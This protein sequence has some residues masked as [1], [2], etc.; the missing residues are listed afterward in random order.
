MTAHSM[1]VACGMAVLAIGALDPAAA[2]DDL[3]LSN[4]DDELL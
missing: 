1:A 4:R 2:F 3:T